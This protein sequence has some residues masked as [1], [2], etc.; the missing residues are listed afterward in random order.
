MPTTK[1]A[2]KRLRQNISRRARNRATCSILTSHVRKVREAVAAANLEAAKTAFLAATK[3]LDHA[4][5]K[6]VLHA[7]AAARLKS[8]L[9]AA[10]KALKAKKG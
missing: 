10:I 2:K 5:T 6:K 4:A 7:N 8:R 9:S 3:S 1:S